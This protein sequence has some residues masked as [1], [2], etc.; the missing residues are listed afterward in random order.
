M[1]CPCFI[2]FFFRRPSCRLRCSGIGPPSVLCR[3]SWREQS[4]ALPAAL[5]VS[6]QKSL[7][8]Q[9]VPLKATAKSR[10]AGELAGLA[11]PAALSASVQALP[12]SVQE[13]LR[14]KPVP[15]KATA[16]SQ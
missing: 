14:S 16:K 15:L 5:L 8:P 12:V 7:R 2:A 6:A 3:S 4:S 11:F 13:R 9:P 1:T 10:R